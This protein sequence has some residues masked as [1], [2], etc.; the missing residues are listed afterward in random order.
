ML[1]T[2]F[3]LILFFSNAPNLANG[4]VFVILTRLG[5]E[6][7]LILGLKKVLYARNFVAIHP[8]FQQRLTQMVYC[9]DRSMFRPDVMIK[10]KWR[11]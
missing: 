10:N 2:A 11:A 1:E 6:A 5:S 4:L 9:L 3:Q 7:L 8:A